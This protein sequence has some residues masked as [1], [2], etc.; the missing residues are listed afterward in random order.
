MHIEP[1]SDVVLIKRQKLDKK[2]SILIPIESPDF[3]E[4]IGT[5]YAAGPDC[6][7]KSGD[8]VLF[9]THGH[10]ITTVDGEEIIVTRYNSIIGKING[11]R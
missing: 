11:S 5:V 2:G 1:L 4:D 3:Q 6:S 9:S 10:Q 8:V 7:L